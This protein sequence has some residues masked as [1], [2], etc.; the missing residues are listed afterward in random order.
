MSRWLAFL[1]G[2][3]VTGGIAYVAY[4]VFVEPAMEELK[5][6]IK[7]LEDRICEFETTYNR[8]LNAIKEEHAILYKQIQELRKTALTLEMRQKVEELFC[9]LAQAYQSKQTERGTQTCV[10]VS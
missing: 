2:V 7:L 10:Y 1:L 8:D 6:R 4:K 9:I 3:G 5:R